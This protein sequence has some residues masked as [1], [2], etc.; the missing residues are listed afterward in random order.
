MENYL[1][2]REFGDVGVTKQCFNL[3]S[4]K[5][6]LITLIKIVIKGFDS[7]VVTDEK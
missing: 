2:V 3:R 7:E 5:K 1:V 4:K 6:P